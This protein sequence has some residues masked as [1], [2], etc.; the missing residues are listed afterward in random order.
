MFFKKNPEWKHII[1]VLDNDT[2]YRRM[3]LNT[4]S[5]TELVNCPA[6]GPATANRIM[7]YRQE[8]G[9]FRDLEEL[10]EIPGIGNSH[11][12]NIAKFFQIRHR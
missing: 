3:D 5:Y 12:Q 9:G 1:T 6:I 7:A 2:L 4:V 8:K 10:K 11:F